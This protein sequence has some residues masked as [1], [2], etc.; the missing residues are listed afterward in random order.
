M[1][2]VLNIELPGLDCGMCGYRTCDELRG[3]LAA[4]PDL[5]KRCIPLS[6]NRVPAEPKSL[7]VADVPSRAGGPARRPAALAP[8][9]SAA[10][11]A[12]AVA[13][14]RQSGPR[15]RFLPGALSRGARP[16]RDHL[17]AQPA[18]HARDG[19]PGGRHAHRPAA[20]HVVRLP[21]HPLR[22]GD[23]GRSPHGRHRVVRDRPARPAAERVQGPWLLHRRGLRG[24][25]R[26]GPLRVE[27]GHA[28]LLPAASCACCSGG[29][30][31]C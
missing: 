13:L 5:I 25:G 4:K 17:A 22:R 10:L 24:P 29:T 27:G 23:G 18:H 11:R 3:Q 1:T 12:G 21:D 9:R 8:G 20:G 16:A 2:Q 26:T 6:E 30:A 15:V 31:V 14:A 7:P 28:L 19:D